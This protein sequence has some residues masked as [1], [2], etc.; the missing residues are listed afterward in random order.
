VFAVGAN[1]KMLPYQSSCSTEQQGS[2]TELSKIGKI[3]GA[4]MMPIVGADETG[5]LQKQT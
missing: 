3:T 1:G 2:G 4:V 5:L